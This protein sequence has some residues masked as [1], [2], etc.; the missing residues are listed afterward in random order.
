MK[1]G[2]EVEFEYHGSDY[3]IVTV[4]DEMYLVKAGHPETLFIHKDVEKILDYLMDDGKKLREVVTR[5]N[6]V[7]HLL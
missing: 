5:I 7:S 2:G 3:S 6:V 1:F 4:K